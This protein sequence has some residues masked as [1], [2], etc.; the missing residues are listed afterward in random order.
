MRD[1][2]RLITIFIVAT[3]M[4]LSS[5]VNGDARAD[6]IW[7]VGSQL[8][9]I[10]ASGNNVYVVWQNNSPDQN[11]YFRR[12]MDGGATFDKVIRLSDAVSGGYATA[13]PQMAV[14]GNYVNVAWM[15]TPIGEN[16]KVLIR[17][18]VDG[19]R[20]FERIINLDEGASDPLS[21]ALSFFTSYGMYVILAVVAVI[22]VP[23]G[24]MLAKRRG[25]TR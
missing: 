8:S 21:R 23:L 6:Q 3:A 17:R 12:S 4:M 24:I 5:H 11:V 15:D 7:S 14:F 19:G 1:N 20:T 22:A 25:G 10:A 2:A 18:S 9:Q 13:N 16:S